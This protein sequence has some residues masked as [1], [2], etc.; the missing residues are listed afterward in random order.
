MGQILDFCVTSGSWN[1]KIA[2]NIKTKKFFLEKFDQFK[3]E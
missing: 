3:K 1:P 2:F